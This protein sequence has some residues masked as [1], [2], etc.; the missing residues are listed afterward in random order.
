MTERQGIIA[1]RRVHVFVF[2]TY[3]KFINV[4]QFPGVLSDEM[5]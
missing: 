1:F 2:K 3:L 5:E 4:L